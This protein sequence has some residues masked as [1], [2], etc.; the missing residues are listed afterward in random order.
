LCHNIKDYQIKISNVLPPS[1][2]YL[3]D[4]KALS[5]PLATKTKKGHAKE[6][7]KEIAYSMPFMFSRA[8]EDIFHFAV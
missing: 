1:P 7:G 2:F 3:S 5:S 6:F 8:I 4:L